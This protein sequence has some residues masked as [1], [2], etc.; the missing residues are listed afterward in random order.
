LAVLDCLE[1]PWLVGGSV[2]SGSYGLPR[3]TNDIDI[4]VDFARADPAEFLRL[5]DPEFYVDHQSAI[6]AI[7]LG[8]PFN[9]IH[10]KAAFKF[11]FFPAATDGFSQS[12]LQRR[13]YVVSAMPGLADIEFAIS[14]PEDT[15]LAKLRWFRRGGETS[16]RQWHDILGVLSVQK[17]TLDHMYLRQWAAQMKLTDLLEKA[18]NDLREPPL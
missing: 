6:E 1:L 7:R 9:V 16:D 2:A 12:E 3:Q 13:R 18:M 11:D 15:I 17:S 10:L 14:S 4:I 5:L 8:R